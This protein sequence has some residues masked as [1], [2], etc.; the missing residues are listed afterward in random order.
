MESW[1]RQDDDLGDVGLQVADKS[2]DPQ[3]ITQVPGRW[4]H[5]NSLAALVWT[6]PNRELVIGG[7]LRCPCQSEPAIPVAAGPLKAVTDRAK[8][9]P[10]LS[11][12]RCLSLLG[13]DLSGCV[14]G[15][16]VHARSLLIGTLRNQ[17]EQEQHHNKKPP[18]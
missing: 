18:R 15:F 12:Y 16:V 9:A 8:T 1:I 4:Q 14:A 3:L 13:D 10:L 6:W 11:C 2:Q 17:G 7:C 5:K